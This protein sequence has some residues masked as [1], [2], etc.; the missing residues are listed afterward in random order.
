MFTNKHDPLV[1][2]VK[3]VMEKNNLRRQVEE[4]LNEELGVSSRK[5]IPHEHLASYDAMLEEAYKCAM[6]E[7]D[8]KD[9][10]GDFHVIT[11]DGKTTVL[12]SNMEKGAREA[13]ER[14]G[15]GYKVYRGDKLPD[16]WEGAGVGGIGR[17]F[18]GKK[19][20][21][22]EA[23]EGSEPRNEKE[24]NLAALKE[25]RDKITHA[26][27]LKGRGV[28]KQEEAKVAV[29]NKPTTTPAK[30]V[31]HALEEKATEAQ[32][33][34][35]AKV[36]HKWKQG[37]EHIGKSEKTVPK[38]EQGR[39]QAIAIALSQAG[40]SKKQKM[41]EN[42]STIRTNRPV[43][44]KK[45]KND[46]SNPTVRTNRPVKED[47]DS[48]MEE[49]RSN[50]EEKLVSVYE[51]GDA[52]MFEEFVSSLTEEQLELLGLSEVAPAV[53]G[54]GMLAARAAAT[55]IGQ[56]AIGA[57]SNLA[58]RGIS[59]LRGSGS[60]PPAIGGALKSTPSPAPL[61]LPKPTG[62]A[63]ATRPTT[64]VA[65][66]GAGKPPVPPSGSGTATGATGASGAASKP[67]LSGGRMGAGTGA[68]IAAGAAGN[69]VTSSTP[70]VTQS[71]ETDARVDAQNAERQQAEKAK[72]LQKEIPG[73]GRSDARD[74]RTSSNVSGS[75]QSTP[76]ATPKPAAPAATPASKP[77][78]ADDRPIAGFAPNVPS[79]QPGG[80]KWG[81][82]FQESTHI[83]ES[84]ESM[85]RSKYLKG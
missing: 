72:Q 55:P 81:N 11:P 37:K 19:E 18:A 77:K 4:A 40:L 38:T 12:V 30:G 60:P 84:L 73:L 46:K 1:D 79:G 8:E 24:A 66:G 25:P 58:Q 45:P 54:A 82:T 50:L 51:S 78:P 83:K 44:T 23:K 47:I 2:S 26:D 13:A 61:A 75:T 80:S 63:V 67:S 64:P 6:K 41:D 3:S 7:A 57:I 59:A 29:G 85:I 56:R 33:E 17:M 53:Y 52:Q 15:K 28:I 48:I 71:Q 62:T 70:T 43:E 68:A 27:V 20:T 21:V 65:S 69:I 39:K 34:K 10:S 42:T 35:V 14:F 5:A 32:K 36:M 9:Y 76:T 49:I 16:T 22:K 31:P 74:T